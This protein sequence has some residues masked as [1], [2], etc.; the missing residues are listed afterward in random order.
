VTPADAYFGRQKSIHA[1]RQRIKQMT[2][3]NRRL[4]RRML[5]A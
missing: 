4:Q 5:A 3:E 1:E 2:I